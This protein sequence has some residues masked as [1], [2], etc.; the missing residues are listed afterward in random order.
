MKLAINLP[1]LVSYQALGEALALC[2]QVGLDP[3]QLVNLLGD[4][5]GGTNALKAR[6]GVVAKLLKGEDPG[7][8]GF[9]VDGGLKDLR[10]ML[11]EGKGRG[12]DL[13]M[14][15]AAIRTFEEAKAKGL[16]NADG[17]AV[18]TYWRARK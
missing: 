5:S 9:D 14:V 11:A 3:E 7:P 6:A 16:G 10:T 18:A 17:F 8:A 2:S 12:L 1:L 4:S 13:P 15:E